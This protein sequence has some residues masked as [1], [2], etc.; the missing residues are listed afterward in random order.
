MSR[1]NA[2]TRRDGP[3]AG[4]TMWE[5]WGAASAF[6]MILLGAA[7]GALERALSRPWPTGSDPAFADFLTQN[8]APILTQSIL[9]LFSSA[10]LIWFLG[11]LR[12]YLLGAEGAPGTL[13]NIVFGAGL[14]S[15]GLNMMGQCAQIVLTLPS[16]S[17][18]APGVASALEDLGLTTLAVANLPLVVMFTAL[19]ILSLRKRAF[20]TWLGWIA[21]FTAIT[22]LLS[23]TSLIPADGALS[24]LGWLTNLLRLV[25]L[26]W[27]IPAAT[28]MI[29]K[30]RQTA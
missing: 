1:A 16:Q 19:A 3:T 26:V 10:V 15:V 21:V 13:T 29:R 27:Y 18:V 11:Y 17:S 7:G 30:S 20:P 4:R 9:F 8:R 14:V 5:T 23:V 28:A 22:S 12:H 24:P 2:D 25:P 6:L